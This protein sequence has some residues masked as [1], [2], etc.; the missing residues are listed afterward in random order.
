MEE[1]YLKDFIIA[2]VVILLIAFGFKDHSLYGK[3]KK[4]P[5]ESKYKKIALGDDLMKQ[6]RNIE[7]SIQDRKQF[8]FTVKRDPL[9]Q[10]LIVK[11]IKDLEKQWKEEVENM[12][13][14]ESTIV[15]EKGRKRAAISFK[16]K[17]KLYS[18][19]DEFAKGK[20]TDIREGKIIYMY[21]GRKGILKIQK[22]PEKPVEI[23]KKKTKAKKTRAYNW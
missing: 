18:I 22:L 14:L 8:K 13:R 11:T 16:G 2:L 21:N 20:I 12:V 15:P 19:G 17:T 3:I 1:K 6:I 23:V 5:K 10:D 9:E 4:I 7:R